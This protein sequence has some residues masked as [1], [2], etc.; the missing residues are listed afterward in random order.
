[1]VKCV[2]GQ[3]KKEGRNNGYKIDVDHADVRH[4]NE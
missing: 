1:M 2:I 4:V 3:V